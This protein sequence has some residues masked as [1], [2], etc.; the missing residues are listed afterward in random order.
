MAKK[1]TNEPYIEP[2]MTHNVLID[3]ME[4][5]GFGN[6]SNCTGMK[7][8][9]INNYDVALQY[10]MENE[11]TYI[12]ADKECYDKF[13]F[14]TSS[15]FGDDDNCILVEEDNWLDAIK[16]VLDMKFDVAIMN[17]PYDRNLHLKIL[18][19]VIPI[20]NKVVNISPVR[21][22]QDPFAK[23]LKT[24]DYKKFEESIS[25]KI[26]TLDIIPAEEA[27]KK[28]DN[29]AFT[30]NLGIYV[31]GNGGY[32]YDSETLLIKKIV[33]KV[34]SNSWENF[35]WQDY[36]DN[37]IIAKTYSLNVAPIHSK[38]SVYPIMCQTYDKQCLVLPAKKRTD[39]KG[40]MGHNG[41]HFEFD[42]ENERLNFYNCYNHRFMQWYCRLWKY[43]VH[44]VGYKVPYFGDYTKP[45]TTKMFC[46]YF[47]ITGY[48]DDEHAVPGSE[49][50]EIMKQW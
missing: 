10:A 5:I 46:D 44:V 20:A 12:T 47:D 22:L 26:E 1:N 24:S 48:I 27:T 43:D 14:F 9:V 13:N 41:G 29:A 6:S 23:Y 16:K 40:G 33:K 19:K 30:M 31:C 42:T 2:V 36:Y 17:P 28:F 7:I 18:E 25:K 49:W 11:V 21:W 39:G 35:S 8:L 38:D 37:K 45:W 4:K 15:D 50:E 32:Q 34:M 3:T